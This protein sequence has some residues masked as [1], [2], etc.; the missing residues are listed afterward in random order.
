[1]FLEGQASAQ[2]FQPHDASTLTADDIALLRS[3]HETVKTTKPE[4]LEH[5]L[6]GLED[7]PGLTAKQRLMILSFRAARMIT[8]SAPAQAVELIRTETRAHPDDPLAQM[9]LAQTAFAAD[10]YST[11]ANAIIAATQL[12][13]DL[14]ARISSYELKILFD[15]LAVGEQDDLSNALARRLFDAG[16]TTGYVGLR[17]SAAKEIVVDLLEKGDV[18]ASGRY[19]V[20]VQIPATLATMLS[21]NRYAPLHRTIAD[22]AGPRLEKQWPIYL[23]EAKRTFESERSA[24]AAD[25]YASALVSAQQ[26]STLLAKFFPFAEQQ[27][28][29]TED[30]E[31]L[32]TITKVA[33]SLARR[34]RWDDSFALLDRASKLL[35][36]DSQNAIN[37][38]ANRARLH[39]VKG[40]FEAASKLFVP[41]VAEAKANDAVGPSTMAWLESYRLCATHRH[42][43]AQAKTDASRLSAS[44]SSKEPSAMAW[45]WLC[46]GQ[47]AAARDSWL[48]AVGDPDKMAMLLAFLQPDVDVTYD[49]KFARE[50]EQEI[51]NLRKDPILRSAVAKAGNIRSWK[52]ADSAP[53]D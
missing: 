32:F 31:W 45:M 6:G 12:Q 26:D 23:A 2:I 11:V 47:P 19:V 33:S 28:V 1:M 4:Q 50:M 17:S 46:L 10:D 42:G 51:A 48:S 16:W 40:D 7:R 20:E 43:S 22:W 36:K 39:L 18:P 24:T 44:D 52:L 27:F 13:P 41:V 49:S 5:A 15:R 14:V 53:K 29:K 21:D 35:I 25:D 34:G 3:I 8:D 37:I 38:S 9:I 30:E